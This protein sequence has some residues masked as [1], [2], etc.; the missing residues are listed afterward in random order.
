MRDCRVP[1]GPLPLAQTLN[2]RV[3]RFYPDKT[4]IIF[5]DLE[6]YVPAKDRQRETPSRMAFSPVLPGHKILGGTFLTFYPM[7]DQVSRRVDIWEW[8]QGS[9]KEVLSKIFQLIQRGWRSIE[10]REQAGSLMLSGI[11]ISHSDVP[12][13]LTRLAAFSIASHTRVYDLICGCRQIDLSVATYCQFS[14]GHSY[15]SYPKSKAALYQ[16]YLN[17]RASESGRSVWDLYDE[18]QFSAIENRSRQEIDDVLAIYRCMFD[19][20][21]ESDYSLKRLKWLEKGNE[22][23]ARKKA[24]E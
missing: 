10:A 14:F 16:K 12:A 9:E 20:K 2:A 21:K 5:F 19:R 8:K 15:F 18:K 3:L 4:K 11:G 1:P 23:P 24:A 17:G 7:Q 13:L 22:R 6:Y